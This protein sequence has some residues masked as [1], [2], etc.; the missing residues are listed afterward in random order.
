MAIPG[1]A[2]V[3]YR[4]ILDALPL[5]WLLLALAFRA[6]ISRA[7]GAALIAGM[8]VNIWLCSVAWSELVA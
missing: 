6:G 7:A 2:Q 3:G 1:F 5:L 8:V 4:F